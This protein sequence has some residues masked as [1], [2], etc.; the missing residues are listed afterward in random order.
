MALHT[1]VNINPT[2]A[3]AVA[4]THGP[5]LNN[6]ALRLERHGDLAGAERKHIEAIQMKEASVGADHVS[7]A[8][9]YNGL[10]ELYLKMELLDKAEEYL[11]QALRVRERKGPKS[12]L[13]TTR[14]DLGRLFEMRG[15]LQAAQ[16]IRLKGAPY[17]I[18]C[19]NFNCSMLQNSLSNLSRCSV[20]KAVF[21]CSQ[22][23]Q[24]AD[25]RRHKK[26]CRRIENNVNNE[27]SHL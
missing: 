15:E 6:E 23:C 5:A 21:Y 18:A 27:T 1:N 4:L 11:N 16:E 22:P 7:T 10:G 17:N 3:Q 8:I 24:R 20:C 14:D 26:Y 9:S 25:W 2:D 19:G 12:D 13:A